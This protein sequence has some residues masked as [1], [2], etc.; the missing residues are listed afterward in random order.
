MFLPWHIAR[1]QSPLLEFSAAKCVLDIMLAWGH[2]GY[3]KH[4]TADSKSSSDYQ[5]F[6]QKSFSPPFFS[7]FPPQEFRILASEKKNSELNPKRKC[8]FWKMHA[9]RFR[10]TNKKLPC[11]Q[12]QNHSSSALLLLGLLDCARASVACGQCQL[13]RCFLPY[14]PLSLSQTK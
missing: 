7:F 3:R 9:L 12:G 11:L 10:K 5:D 13:T 1:Q 6:H 14:S 8:A 2:I 4:Y